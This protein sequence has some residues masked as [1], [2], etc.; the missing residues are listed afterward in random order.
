MFKSVRSIEERDIAP[1]TRLFFHTV[2]SAAGSGYDDAQRKAW[3]PAIPETNKWHERI[4]RQYAYVIE[5]DE[6]L[7]G[8]MTMTRKGHIDLAFTRA[9]IISKGA[10]SLLYAA[11]ETCAKKHRINHLTTDASKMACGFFE[12]HGWQFTE[13]QQVIRGDIAL[14]NYKMT[15][16]L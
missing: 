12:R 15:K 5:D 14:T 16:S 1:A 10:G 8:F 3:A 9:D 4:S 2:H 11:I 6:G 13:K 7:A